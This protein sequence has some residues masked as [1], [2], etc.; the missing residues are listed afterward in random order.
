MMA[1]C[2][3]LFILE[4]ALAAP[5]MPVM[6]GFAADSALLAASTSGPP[7]SAATAWAR[8]LSTCSFDAMLWL[9][10][11]TSLVS[12]EFFDHSLFERLTARV[13]R[14]ELPARRRR[15]S[16]W[17]VSVM[18][19]DASTTLRSC[20]LA[21]ALPSPCTTA[22][23]VPV[24]SFDH[25]CLNW[26]ADMP[27]TFAHASSCFPFVDTCVPICV[28]VFEKAV[29][30]ACDSMPRDA[31]AAAM[32]RISACDMPACVPADAMLM[33]MS[34]ILDSVVAMLLPRPTIAEP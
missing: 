16:L 6:S 7:T 33:A 5:S 3:P 22:S 19:S 21:L 26:S 14:L 29:P 28:M 2:S 34:E 17:R 11:A 23:N 4:K 15:K 1:C 27:A 32:P 10:F 13:T 24:A 25:D 31:V 9:R 30:P 18:P 12:A 20:P 8:F